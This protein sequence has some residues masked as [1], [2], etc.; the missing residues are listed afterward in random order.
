MLI[1][2]NIFNRIGAILL[3]IATALFITLDLKTDV[4]T[5]TP[6]MRVCVGVC[7]G[8]ILLWV[9]GN[10]HRK[11]LRLFGQGLIGSGIGIFYLTVYGAYGFF[12]LI[13][14]PIAL[15]G[16]SLVNLVA[17]WQAIRYD[18]LAI[19]LIGW[20]GGICT[21]LLVQTSNMA[22]FAYLLFFQLGQLA[23]P[24]RKPRWTPIVEGLAIFSI[25]LVYAVWYFGHPYNHTLLLLPFL[26]AYWAL[27]LAFDIYRQTLQRMDIVENRL[28]Y[29][30]S[31]AVCFGLAV[32]LLIAQARPALLPYAMLSIAV[33]HGGLGLWLAITRRRTCWAETG[34][35]LAG[36]VF[37]ALATYLKYHGFLLINLWAVEAAAL[38]C[39]GL[40]WKR[41][42]V[43]SAALMLFGVASLKLLLT[44]GA[45]A[46]TPIADFTPVCNVR[47]LTFVV[48]AALIF[49]CAL[50]CKRSAQKAALVET[51]HYAWSV[52]IAVLITVEINDYFNKVH[53]AGFFLA[54]RYMVMAVSWTLYS[55]PLVW[56]GLRR[57]NRALQMVGMAKLPLG[58]LFLLAFGMQYTPLSAFTPVI[59][60]RAI[61]FLL[62]IVGL[63][64]QARWLGKEGA[65]Y[66]WVSA[67]IDVIKAL[68][69]ILVFALLTVE[70]VDL[71]DKM[72][73]SQAC[74]GFLYHAPHAG[75]HLDAV[76][77]RV[78]ALCALSPFG[79]TRGVGA[80]RA[81][82]PR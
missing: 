43:W 65:A 46:Y 22:V 57:N 80:H 37:L 62:V 42:Y 11:Q 58:V 64:L 52:I 82:D 10:A 66:P 49:L 51:L 78:P 76:R 21:P 12:H 28:Y 63:G 16:M 25:Y 26:A 35:L 44:A 27:F 81:M 36:I 48:L 72:Q 39:C 33:V 47:C 23:L 17:L 29:F 59:N 15:L 61:P 5:P 8:V 19:V 53:P 74:L 69:A 41:D 67:I 45:L 31:N 77:V 24:V 7:S 2:G 13:P 38:V 9:G 20:F 68:V 73:L 70:T 55:L 71:F 6:L 1:G 3:I 30:V 18:S 54:A 40:R 79:D 50:L 60:M 32:Y 56:F 34:N 14:L 4:F 75:D